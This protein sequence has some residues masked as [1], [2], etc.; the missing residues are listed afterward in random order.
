MT[1]AHEF[2]SDESPETKIKFVTV[3][4]TGA[5]HEDKVGERWWQLESGFITALC[6]RLKLEAEDI[7]VVP[8][9]WED[10]PNSEDRRRSAANRL[11]KGLSIY[12][13]RG[14]SYCLIGHS[15]G[16]SVIY[17]ALLQSAKLRKA[18]LTGLKQWCTVGTP[19]LNYCANRFMWQRLNGLGLTAYT[20]GIVAFW[21]AVAYWIYYY[22]MIDLTDK[23]Q[24]KLSG[25]DHESMYNFCIAL[26]IYA[27]ICRVTLAL[28]ERRR[29]TWFTKTHKRR[30]ENWYG[31]RWIG[32]WHQQD[33]A[34]SA[35]ANIKGVRGPIIP[36]TFLQPLIAISQLVFVLGFGVAVCWDIIFGDAELL[37]DLTRFF[38]VIEDADGNFQVDNDPFLLTILVLFFLSM[39]FIL[40]WVFTWILK[41]LAKLTGLLVAPLL[42]GVIWTSVR[43]RAWGD[44]LLKEDVD[45]IGSSPPEFQRQ[46]PP[47][48]PFVATPLSQF[49]DGHAIKTLNNVRKLLGMSG[50]G[51]MPH[52]VKAGLS[53]SLKWKELIHTAYFEVPEF[54]DLL[55]IALNR[56]GLCDLRDGFHVSPE[57][58]AQI[59]DWIDGEDT[60]PIGEAQLAAAMAVPAG[61]N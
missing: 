18:P 6:Q 47:L 28:L 13:E 52:D 23:E 29:K 39:V 33:E 21:I 40:V 48:P 12:D 27:L 22:F 45:T 57:V 11:L 51:E 10:G 8:F 15:H 60:P 61:T 43:Q 36:A 34:I 26:V 56:G 50:D 4:G 44:D 59:E 9:R 14:I 1:D 53:D 19:F 37:N 55:A 58:R 30:V 16:G 46:F 32:L 17:N 24:V 54:I 41:F 3:H 49:S 7:E 38:A 2:S 42:N 31:E 20:T 5:G 35:L 25:E